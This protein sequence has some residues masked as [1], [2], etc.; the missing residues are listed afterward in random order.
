MR[1]PKMREIEAAAGVLITAGGVVA[2]IVA[3]LALG[4]LL[5]LW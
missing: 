4:Y 5:S 1:K 3:C 2:G